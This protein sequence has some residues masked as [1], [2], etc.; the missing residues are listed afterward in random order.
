MGLAISVGSL[1][2]ALR[3][4]AD[5]PEFI[6]SLREEYADINRLLRHYGLPPHHE[7][8]VL[9][10]LIER[11][12]IGS[13]AYSSWHYLRRVVAFVVSFADDCFDHPAEYQEFLDEWPH[14]WPADNAF[15]ESALDSNESHIVCHTDCGGYFVPVDFPEPLRETDD[16]PIAG[17]WLGSSQGAMREL[18]LAARFL[19]V[20]LADGRLDDALAEAIGHEQEDAH[21]HGIARKVWLTMFENTRLSIEYGTAIVFR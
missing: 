8:E 9:P 12:G 14:E 11:G 1:A 18:V 20:P 13:I 4:C 6:A 16:C 17:G 7:P 10:E 15:I 19:G 3:T 5:D 21:P 2:Y